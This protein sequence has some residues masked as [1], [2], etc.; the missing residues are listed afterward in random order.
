MSKITKKIVHGLLTVCLI[1]ILSATT[2]CAT[3]VAYGSEKAGYLVST[4]Q[5]RRNTN[6][7][8]DSKLNKTYKGY[9]TYGAKV[10][11]D[12]G[13]VTLT[14][15]KSSPNKVKM[16]NKADTSSFAWARTYGDSQ[17]GKIYEFEICFNRK[18]MDKRSALKNKVTA[19][20]EVGHTLGLLDLCEKRNEN[21]L[22]CGNGRRKESVTKPMPADIKG[23]KYATR[24]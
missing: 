2:V 22:M 14:R 21:K 18:N 8:D 16:T 11:K 7:Y 9:M 24:K 23:A 20:H 13:V 19:A 6:T 5:L 12:C 4:K 1:A 17:T 3:M 15:S 10:W